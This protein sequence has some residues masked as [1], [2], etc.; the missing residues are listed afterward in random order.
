MHRS[1]RG[2][3][4]NCTIRIK[5]QSRYQILKLLCHNIV[6][7]GEIQQLKIVRGGYGK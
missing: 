2:L 1:G 6:L 4:V 3:V 7:F 5:R